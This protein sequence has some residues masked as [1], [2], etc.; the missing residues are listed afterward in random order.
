MR[1]MICG[2]TLAVLAAARL[3]VGVPSEGP[4]RLFEGRDLFALEVVSDPQIRPDGAQVA[5]VRAGYDIMTDRPRSSIWLVDV[6][7]GAETPLVSGSGS[8][9]SLSWSPDGKRL[10][11]VSSES[12][13]AGSA[14]R[15]LDI[16]GRGRAAY[17]PD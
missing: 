7:S 5:Y 2:L 9:S 14:L 4:A 3:A 6:A 1:N 10:A 12:D 13:G 8:H 15:A 17:R 16:D 11:Y